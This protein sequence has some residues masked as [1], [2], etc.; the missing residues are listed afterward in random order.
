MLIAITIPPFL[1][2]VVPVATITFA[3]QPS[4]AQPALPAGALMHARL[5]TGDIVHAGLD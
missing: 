2:F 1:K 4:E 3:A 5:E